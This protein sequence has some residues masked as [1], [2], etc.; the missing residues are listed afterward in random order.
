[1]RKALLFF[2]VVV[3]NQLAGQMLPSIPDRLVNID[4]SNKRTDE[5]LRDIALQGKFEFTWDARLFDPAKPVTL[6]VQQITVRKAINLIFGNTITFRVQGNYVVLVATL[7]PVVAAPAAPKRNE[8]TISGYI[9]DGNNYVI[10]YAS[11]YD[12]A[13]LASALSNQIGFYEL[14]LEAGNQ[15]VRVKIS[16]DKYLDTFIVVTPSSNQTIDVVM[17]KIPAPAF[18]APVVADSVPVRSDTIA[19]APKRKIENFP[20]LDSLIGFEQ[21]MQSKN[22]KETLRRGGQISFL[23]FISTNGNM[24]GAV[25]NKYS[26]NVI[27]G[28]TGGTSVAELGG[29]FNIDRGDVQWVQVAGAFNIVEGNT[30]GLQLSGGANVNF[31][32]LKGLQLTGGSNF[33]FDSLVGIQFAGGTNL[34]DGYVSGFQ[35]AGGANIATKNLDGVQ[36]AGGMNLVAGKVS[37][38]Q[39][40]GGLNMCMDTM[41][42]VQAA[43]MNTTKHLNGLQIGVL[44]YA[45]S[46]DK[47]VPVGL[48]SVVVTGLHEFEFASTE[49]GFLDFNLRTGT[50]KFY[51]VINFGFDP[52]Y[53]ENVLW[54][55]GYGIGHRFNIHPNFDVGMDFTVHHVSSRNFSAYTNEWAKFQL[56]AEWRIARPI[57]IAAGPVFNY[58]VT[59]SQNNEL[60]RFEQ[61]PVF[62]GSPA[63]GF[64]D[65]AW[66]GATISI[67]IF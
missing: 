3:A 37:R 19:A 63:E 30:R 1:M 32:T 5:V 6:H 67:R 24:S 31:G 51:N 61:A 27:G 42:G 20:L 10:A 11:I 26:F 29:V 4:C 22:L 66:V 64:R 46:C 12:S 39:L 43:V 54:M 59:G 36:M 25:R 16:R 8:F 48:I 23:P 13:S 40:A 52:S 18:I 45:Y 49:R 15:P 65:L 53:P 41:S 2:F 47:G 34:I 44:N 50:K 38:A 58:Y 21:I 7:P 35:I 62:S 17:R 28:F 55:F 57:A 56:T 14:K 9:I 60:S 33:L